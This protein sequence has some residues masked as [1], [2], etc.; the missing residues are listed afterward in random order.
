MEI[1]TKFNVGDK[2]YQGQNIALVGNTG[3]SFGSHLHF[4]IN[5]NGSPVNPVPYLGI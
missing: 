5:L 2:V 1:V 4:E 3:H